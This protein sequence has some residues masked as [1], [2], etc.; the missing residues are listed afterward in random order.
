MGNDYSV[1]SIYEDCTS[2]VPVVIPDVSIYV[3]ALL[4]VSELAQ[5]QQQCR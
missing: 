3:H 2:I 1:H 4:T 5:Q